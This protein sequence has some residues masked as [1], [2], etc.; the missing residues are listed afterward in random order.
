M[1]SRNSK[2]NVEIPAARTSLL[3]I[4][5]VLTE[6]TIWSVLP[7]HLKQLASINAFKMEIKSFMFAS[8]TAD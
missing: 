5:F 2:Y 1:Y 6:A 7:D 4:N 3:K 8:A